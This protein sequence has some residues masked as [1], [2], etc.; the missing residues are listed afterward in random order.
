MNTERAPICHCHGG[1]HQ[2]SLK[3]PNTKM[4]VTTNVQ[5][6][7]NASI[8][9]GREGQSGFIRNV[10]MESKMWS[11]RNKRES[12]IMR[13]ASAVN[14]LRSTISG[15]VEMYKK[16]MYFNQDQGHITT[17]SNTLGVANYMAKTA[18]VVL[19][20]HNIS[21]VVL[22]SRKPRE[23]FSPYKFHVM[24]DHSYLR[25]FP[26]FFFCVSDC[27]SAIQYRTPL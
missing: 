20:L 8:V 23:C 15:S 16:C 5:G 4:M 21:K 9:S 25:N 19:G 14:A 11:A 18:M 26:D 1:A 10:E 27:Y 22:H 6:R 12:G 17:F 13:I 7:S 3:K 2:Q 24:L